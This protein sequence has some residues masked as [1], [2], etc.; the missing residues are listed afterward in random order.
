MR[1][2]LIS[3]VIVCLMLTTFSS[4]RAQELIPDQN[5]RSAI[6]KTLKKKAD[7]TLTEEDL[8]KVFILDADELEIQS[9]AGLEKC[10]NLAQLTA[11]GNQISDLSPL[12]GLEWLSSLDLRGNQVRD[13]SPL[14]EL[15]ELRWTFLEGN[16]IQDLSVLVV[17]ARQDIE[18]KRE[19]APYWNLYV[20]EKALS[21]AGRVQADELKSLGVRLHLK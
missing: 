10:R 20:G 12:S 4:S 21:D 7:E 14:S 5:L 11:S 13:L 6:L 9:L 19:F 3:L 1:T 17:M 15:T 16:P 2:R 8:R 18:S